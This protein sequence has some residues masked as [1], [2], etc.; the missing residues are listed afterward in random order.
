[1]TTWWSL[2]QL[3]AIRPSSLFSEHSLF[4]P[5]LDRPIYNFTGSSNKIALA[6]SRAHFDA[7]RFRR[8]TA[9]AQ[10]RHLRGTLA[11]C[12][13]EIFL[14]FSYFLDIK[15]VDDSGKRE[16]CCVGEV[17]RGGPLPEPRHFQLSKY[18]SLSSVAVWFSLQMQSNL[19]RRQRILKS[20]LAFAR[21]ARRCFQSVCNKRTSS[22]Y[23]SIWEAGL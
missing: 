3:V 6:V 8:V 14:I 21:L 10:Q 4:L 23:A 5:S 16:K 19:S 18:S 22:H 20:L 13:H 12:A 9:Q 7:R 1:M 17:A 15:A 11:G 2:L